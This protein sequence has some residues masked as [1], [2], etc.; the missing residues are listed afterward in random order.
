MLVTRRAS[1]AAYVTH[2]DWQV[3]KSVLLMLHAALY[4]MEVNSPHW[5]SV[6]RVRRVTQ[7]CRKDITL[8]RKVL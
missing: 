3:N 8:T 4:D 1:D 6:G 5:S 2:V 7:L